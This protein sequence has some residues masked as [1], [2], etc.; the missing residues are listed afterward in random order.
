[1]IDRFAI[2]RGGG[3]RR[4]DADAEI[5]LKESESLVYKPGGVF[6]G[7]RPSWFYWGTGT[8]TVSEPKADP[9]PRKPGRPRRILTEAE[10]SEQRSIWRGHE[11]YFGL[12]KYLHA[13]NREY[14]LIDGRAQKEP[15]LLTTERFTDILR[16]FGE[17]EGYRPIDLRA[18]LEHK[19]LPELY[20]M[21]AEYEEDNKRGFIQSSDWL[22]RKI[23]V[24][25]N[26]VSVVQDYIG[27]QYPGT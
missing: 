19:A 14:L 23:R 27:A 17:S 11:L 1:M 2:R 21:R 18:L 22:S 9:K 10:R 16:K 26:I 6:D 13:A 7:M 20:R 25:H 8:P 15:V 3:G 4:S 12:L 24:Q 5:C